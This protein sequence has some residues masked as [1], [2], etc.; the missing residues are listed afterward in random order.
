MAKKK[1]P[2]HIGCPESLDLGLKVGRVSF[3]SAVLIILAIFAFRGILEMGLFS[4]L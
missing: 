2:H 4:M 3:S 1:E